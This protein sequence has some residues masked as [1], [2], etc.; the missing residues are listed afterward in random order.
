M[1]RFGAVGADGVDLLVRT[2]ALDPKKRITAR[3]MLEHRWWRTDPKPTRK[4]DLPRK[5]GGEEKMGADLKRRPGMLED[6]SNS[7]GAKVA[8]K[9][10]FGQAK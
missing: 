3:E 6:E 5:S 1:G 4:E 10:D 7:R 8:R 2:V 9:L